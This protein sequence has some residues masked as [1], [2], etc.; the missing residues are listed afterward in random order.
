MSIV[1]ASAISAI[2]NLL[3]KDRE[4]RKNDNAHRET[5]RHFNVTGKV[6]NDFNA[7]RDGK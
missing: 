5:T 1:D 3:G 4:S 6:T 2:S 7:D